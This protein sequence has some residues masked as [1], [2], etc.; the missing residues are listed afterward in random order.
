MLKFQFRLLQG[1][2]AKPFYAIKNE[3]VP[4]IYIY[5]VI[6][7]M[8]G[9][10]AQQFANDI[11]AIDAPEIHVRINSPGGDVFAAKAMV[12]QM[13]GHKAKIVAIIDGLAASAATTI[14]IGA[15]E[16]RMAPGGQFMIHNAWSFVGGDYRD[17]ARMSDVLK[18]VND[19]IVQEYAGKTG[20]SQAQ[21]ED[22]MNA[23]TW[24]NADEALANG[25][26]DSIVEHAPKATNMWDLSGYD[27][28][29]KALLETQLKNEDTF[30][31]EHLQ[32]HLKMLERIA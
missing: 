19:S 9:V 27:K 7:D 18:K 24:F 23:E 4:T 5:D 3:G 1:A 16:V 2:A 15:D 11:N 28:V 8:W 25:F 13:K 17:M 10:G 29:P 30:D 14:A 31:I 20:K 21:I 12:E 32:R 22:W 6:S 26:I